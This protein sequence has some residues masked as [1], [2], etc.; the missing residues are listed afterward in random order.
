MRGSLLKYWHDG[1]HRTVTSLSPTECL[2]QHTNLV[3]PDPAKFWQVKWPGYGWHPFQMIIN[4]SLKFFISTVGQR[5]VCPLTCGPHHFQSCSWQCLSLFLKCFPYSLFDV[6]SSVCGLCY[7]LHFKKNFLYIFLLEFNLPI[8]SVTPSAHPI[9]CLP[10]CLLQTSL[11]ILFSQIPL[12][13][14]A[15]GAF[16]TVATGGAS[17][18][19]KILQKLKTWTSQDYKR[20]I[21]PE[22][23][24]PS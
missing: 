9:K 11:A 19:S 3:A 20:Y 24:S 14:P 8:Y 7:R 22:S 12:M 15:V 10:Q 5:T 18:G 4:S 16:C 6:P 2:P 17:R 13:N 23:V 1:R 21:T